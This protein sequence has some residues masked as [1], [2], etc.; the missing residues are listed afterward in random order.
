MNS[1]QNS[2]TK[3]DAGKSFG[4]SHGSAL[5]AG[6]LI[7]RGDL[8]RADDGRMLEMDN[9]GR[10]LGVRV[11]GAEIKKNGRWFRPLPNAGDQGQLHDRK[12]EREAD[13]LLAERDAWQ[14]KAEKLARLVENHF[15]EDFGEFSN[16]ND[17]IERAID[18]LANAVITD[19]SERSGETFGG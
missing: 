5:S 18:F 12:L 17:P 7:Q 13:E 11:L 1:N 15:A 8:F 4:E 10:L 6:E 19:G 14:E 2:P 16:R 3:P 9:L